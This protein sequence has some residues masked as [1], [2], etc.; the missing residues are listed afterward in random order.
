MYFKSI[1]DGINK[2]K[3]RDPS[4]CHL[5]VKVE[6]ELFPSLQPKKRYNKPTQITVN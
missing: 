3:F 6:G 2:D 1:F 5:D 4:F